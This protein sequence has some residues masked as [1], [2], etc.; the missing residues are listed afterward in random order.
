MRPP[1]TGRPSPPE[2]ESLFRPWKVRSPIK[3]ARRI[4]GV[5]ATSIQRL[6]SGEDEEAVLATLSLHVAKELGK[7]ARRHYDRAVARLEEAA[8]GGIGFRRQAVGE[9]PGRGREGIVD[10]ES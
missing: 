6:N 5:L 8:G 7:E 2:G 1:R 3:H 4:D 10:G 9:G